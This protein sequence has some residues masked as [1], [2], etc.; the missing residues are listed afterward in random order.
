MADRRIRIKTRVFLFPFTALST[1]ILLVSLLASQAKPGAIAGNPSE[2]IK[3][4]EP[5]FKSNTMVEEALQRRR[6]TR[7]YGEVPVSLVEVSQLLW[8]A[9]GITDLQGHRTSPS[10][11]AL[12][13]LELYILAGDVKDLPPGIYSYNPHRH[14][15]IRVEQGDRRMELCTAALGQLSVKKAPAVIVFSAV[16][17]R[18][19]VKYGERGMRY[20]HMEAGHAAQNVYLQAVTLNLGTLVIG[21]FNDDA[22][23]KV[24]KMS[25]R[26][27][28]LYILPVGKK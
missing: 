22:V 23:K 7:E 20:V 6:S 14:E 19:T 1:I 21:A 4:P 17:E 25:D 10:A 12:Y 15:L 5:H 9:Q 28:P 3:L 16:Y 24:M 26:E 11:G 8:A 2:R 13:P 27:Q 18:T